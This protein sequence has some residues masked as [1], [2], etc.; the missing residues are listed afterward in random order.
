M[1]WEV[2]ILGCSNHAGESVLPDPMRTGSSCV[3]HG[4]SAF[5]DSDV[6]AYGRNATTMISIP[7]FFPPVGLERC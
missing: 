2:Q 6:L 7:Q 4:T 1:G 5:S 3:A